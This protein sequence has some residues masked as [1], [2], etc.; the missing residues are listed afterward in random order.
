MKIDGHPEHFYFLL[1]HLRPTVASEKFLCANSFISLKGQQL[2]ADTFF[3]DSGD[4]VC[5]EELQQNYQKKGLQ[6]ID[7]HSLGGGSFNLRPIHMTG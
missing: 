1:K 2:V 4:P 7:V 5:L 3:P 6:H